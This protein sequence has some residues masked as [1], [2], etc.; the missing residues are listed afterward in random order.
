MRQELEPIETRALTRGFCVLCLAV[1]AFSQRLPGQEPGQ[2]P[3][4]QGGIGAPDDN[5]VQIPT[6]Q[7]QPGQRVDISEGEIEVEEF[8]R[9][10]SD[11]T[12]MPVFVDTSQLLTM[13]PITVVAPIIMITGLSLAWLQD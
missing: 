6:G 11:Y 3:A 10:L 9:F 13:K 5:L 4:D 8:L 1:L 12:G 2:E 7:F